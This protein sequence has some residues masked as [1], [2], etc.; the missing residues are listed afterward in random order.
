MVHSKARIHELMVS[1]YRRD[2]KTINGFKSLATA[3]V[4]PKQ[5]PLGQDIVFGLA[6]GFMVG[7]LY[8]SFQNLGLI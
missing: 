8:L 3:M 6:L 5:M 4:A 2:L 1:D 7:V